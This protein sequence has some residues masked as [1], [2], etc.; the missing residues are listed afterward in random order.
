MDFREMNRLA[1]QARSLDR[2][3]RHLRSP[4]MDMF[5]KQLDDQRH[6][7][8]AITAHSLYSDRYR[9]VIWQYADVNP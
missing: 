3:T 6:L 2:L 5:L 1:D 9:V 8:A 4:A 7:T